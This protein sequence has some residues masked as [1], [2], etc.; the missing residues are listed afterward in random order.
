MKQKTTAICAASDCENEF[1]LYRTTDKYCSY[2]CKRANTTVKPKKMYKIPHRSKKET[3][4]LGEY[5]KLRADFLNL[6]ENKICP[7]T[8][9]P[10][11]DVHHKKGRTGDLLLDIRFWLAVSRTGHDKIES[12]PN[13]AK[14]MGYSLNRLS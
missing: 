1:K 12:N 8:G 13:W 2:E 5:Y 11:T 14:K 3:K 7:V 10:T 6:P 4:R 9:E